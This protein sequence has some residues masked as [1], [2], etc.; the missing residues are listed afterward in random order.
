MW[1]WSAKE[2]WM[3]APYRLSW[4][5]WKTTRRYRGLGCWMEGS[6][7]QDWGHWL[8]EMQCLVVVVELACPCLGLLRV[9]D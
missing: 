4:V 9:E 6:C 1:G 2:Y 7:W 5:R 8:A 3:E